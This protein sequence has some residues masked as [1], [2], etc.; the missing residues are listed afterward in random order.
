LIFR[1]AGF[2]FEI[3]PA[4]KL[5]SSD[6][7]AIQQLSGGPL[8]G[9]ERVLGGPPWKVCL[10]E[11]G[12]R[13]DVVAGEP[14]AVTVEGH[15]I[16]ATHRNFRATVDPD[17][18]RVVLSRH[19]SFVGALSVTLRVALA[20]RLPLAGGVPLHSAGICIDGKGIVFFG[21]SGAGKSTIAGLS[22]YPVFSD[23]FV[24]LAGR[25][26]FEIG[27]SGFWGT[28]EGGMAP[29]GFV[30]LSAL[31]GLQKAEKYS[32]TRLLPREALLRLME[33][34]TIPASPPLWRGAMPILRSLIE[35]VPV[36]R[37]AWNPSNLP[38]KELIHDL[39]VE[40][41]AHA[42]ESAPA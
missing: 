15:L 4:D 6:R 33:V 11:G 42:T 34:V 36:F 23:E 24:I 32:L 25:D 5:T 21:P 8:F 39:G 38:W 19:A 35:S 18:G 28:L 37:M 14:A 40:A 31:V 3:S 9:V 30:P 2:D 13:S 41:A 16:L 26:P 10:E 29:R 1:L 12:L 17:L 20:C 22:P 27:S 7:E